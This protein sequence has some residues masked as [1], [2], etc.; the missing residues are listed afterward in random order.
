MYF[1]YRRSRSQ[2]HPAL[3]HG[4][5][6]ETVHENGTG[7]SPVTHLRAGPQYSFEARRPARCGRGPA[8][9]RLHRRPVH[10]AG[11]GPRAAGAARARVRA[12]DAAVERG[13]ARRRDGHPEHSRKV[14]HRFEH[15]CESAGPE[16]DRRLGVHDYQPAVDAL[17][18]IALD[19]TREA[20]DCGFGCVG[21]LMIDCTCP[22]KVVYCSS[23]F[24]SAYFFLF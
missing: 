16:G 3:R 5:R 11:R 15:R 2:R 9:L 23:L 8:L 6:L 17:P 4:G 12:A 10:Q 20:F 18:W 19:N 7:R 22:A 1:T 21:N 24:A 13:R 14:D